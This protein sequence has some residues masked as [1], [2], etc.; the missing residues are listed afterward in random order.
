M[1]WIC[2]V[3][4]KEFKNRNQAHSCARVDLEDHFK[5]KSPHVR[6]IF[7]RLIQE[8]GK[9]GKITLNPVKTSIQVKALS[10]ALAVKAKRESVEIEFQLDREDSS[11]PVYKT[12]RI[13]KNRVLHFAV[14][15]TP[16][17]VNAKLVD[18]LRRSFELA[19]Q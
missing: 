6:E 1:S 2:P 4:R 12:F 3:C 10:T 18:R 9:F 5:N 7:E 8:L 14:L 19:S 13:S 17:D 16:R 11:P 15:R